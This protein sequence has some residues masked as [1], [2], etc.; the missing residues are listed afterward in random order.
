MRTGRSSDSGFSSP[1]PTGRRIRWV[2]LAAL[3]L[4]G[5]LLLRNKTPQTENPV[6]RPAVPPASVE[7]PVA[8]GGPAL[9]PAV[10]ELAG[11]LNAAETSARDDLQVLDDILRL[12]R[13]VMGGNPEG[14]NEDI[15]AA[16]TGS[17]AKHWVAFPPDHPAL[18]DGRLVDRWG[19]PFWFHPLSGDL[20]EIRSAGPDRDL[21]TTD[22]VN[23]P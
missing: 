9:D 19:S 23:G 18:R 1:S 14:L 8:V 4:L 7:T 2:A 5:C 3:I 13:Q 17:N 15:T 11:R 6:V 10:L 21:F 20:M 22:D 16:L 12:Y